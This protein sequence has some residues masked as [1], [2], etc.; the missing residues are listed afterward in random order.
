V[1]TGSGI[2]AIAAAKLG[3][4]PVEAVDVDSDAVRTAR[5]NARLNGAASIIRFRRQDFRRATRRPVRKYSVVCANLISSLLVEERE[6]LLS[7]VDR[8]GL[9]V[10]AGILATEFAGVQ[11]AYE[12]AGWRVVASRKEEEWRSGAFQLVDG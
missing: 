9:L 1:G 12:A 2:L 10:L 5:R 11:Q 8:G 3:Y 7:G 6:R 4:G